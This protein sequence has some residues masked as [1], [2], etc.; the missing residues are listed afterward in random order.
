M[1]ADHNE[2][3]D[4]RQYPGAADGVRLAEKVHN[5]FLKALS[6]R[7]DA[8]PELCEA[9][10]LLAVVT[11]QNKFRHAASIIRGTRLGRSAIDDREALRRMASFPADRQH[12]AAG[13]VASQM[14]GSGATEAQVQAIASRLR[15][16]RR[17]KSNGQNSSVRRL[18]SGKPGA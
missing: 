1:S 16:K 8:T 13:A 2:R 3:E 7:S 9:L 11:R 10:D 5:A 17:G 4:R 14:A 15:R 12:E 6:E 18:G